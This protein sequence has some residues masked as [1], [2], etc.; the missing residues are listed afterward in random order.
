MFGAGA[1]LAGR[2]WSWPG[3][4]HL[5]MELSERDLC[6]KREREATRIGAKARLEKRHASSIA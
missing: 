6:A 3:R 2:R 1:I 4:R 5:F